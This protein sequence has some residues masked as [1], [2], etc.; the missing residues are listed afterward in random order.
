M[1]GRHPRGVGELRDLGPM[2]LK[3][4]QAKNFTQT[5][6]EVQE[7]V[8]KTM[9]ESTKRLNAKMDEKRKEL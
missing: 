9:F 8:K 2:E 7:Q 4:G 6:Q 1:Y 3:S 5:I